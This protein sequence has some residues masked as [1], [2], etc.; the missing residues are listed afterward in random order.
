MRKKHSYID[1]LF[2]VFDMYPRHYFV[3]GSFILAF[4]I[5]IWEVFTYTIIDHD[6]YKKIADDQ[7]IWEVSV[8]VTRGSILSSNG[9]WAILATSV[10]LNDLAIDPT[11][12]WDRAKLIIFLRD[13]IYKESC[14]SKTQQDCE[15][16]V[17]KFLRV[18]ELENFVFNEENIKQKIQDYLVKKI[19]QKKVTS[20]LLVQGLDLAITDEVK[21]LW[22]TGIYTNWW[23]I[24][25]NPEEIT[26]AVAVSQK[27]SPLISFPEESIQHAIRKR[28]IRYIPLLS[29][30]SIDESSAIREYIKNERDAVKKGFIDD[31]DSISKF[32]ILSPNP[33]R[34]YPENKIASQVLWFVDNEWKWHYWIEWYFNDTLK[35]EAWEIVSRKDI[36]GRT[37]DPI[38]LDKKSLDREGAIITT[39]IDKNIQNSVEEILEAGVK[40]YRAN[41]GSIIVMNPQNGKI[42]AMANYPKYN[43][44][45][46][47]EVYELEQVKYKDYQNPSNELIWKWVL[48]EDSQLWKEFYFDSKKIL[49]RKATRPELWNYA[50]KKYKYKNDFGAE[51][52]RNAI[53]SD[54]YEPG[55]IMKAITMAVWIDAWEIRRDDF[56][57]NDGPLFIDSF[58]IS[59]IASECRGYHTFSHALNYS[60]NVWMVRIVQKVGKSLLH[61]YLEE[62]WF[63]SKTDVTLEWEVA[64]P[65]G[66]YEKWP[67]AKLFTTSYGLWV[68]VNQLQ[69]AVAYSA[70]ANWGMLLR[71]Q[72]VEKIDYKDGKVVTFKEEVIRQVISKETSDIMID[73]LVDG[74]NNWVAQTGKVEWYAIAGK[75]GT[76]QIAYKWWYES[77][78]VP[79]STNAS[80]AWF[81]PAQDPKFVIVVKLHRPRTSNYGW[82]TSAYIFADVAK[83]LLDYYKIP[84]LRGEG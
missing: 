41:K 58:K 6:F 74:V 65:L 63:G 21:A 71:P 82:S 57:Q 51:V 4:V 68:S 17:L 79:G 76:S 75:T 60:C 72:I 45:R 81:G 55:S 18:V 61:S 2:S 42:V 50:L 13:V 26:N 77:G 53:I 36:K 29:R 14:A 66:N 64:L 1:T 69:M 23:N 31:E 3:L 7:Q 54:L 24:Y 19:G 67:R 84:Q 73:V 49:L 20:V 40:K 5:I 33:H 44:N 48:L 78:F 83:Y 59:D 11:S 30:L 37:I 80:F 22:L 12:I 35:W 25:V 9:W 8:P 27:L 32:L 15:D 47:W 28:E 39:T 34:Y 62:F 43:P 70:L 16:S 56:Y 38:D 10:R 52:Y 46:P